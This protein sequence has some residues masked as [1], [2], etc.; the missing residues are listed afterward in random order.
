MIS[1]I[2]DVPP[3]RVVFASAAL[4][5]VGEEAERLKFARTLVIATPGSGA[6]LG[7]EVLGLL[8]ARAMGLHA[9]AVVH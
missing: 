5:R 7:K 8:G 2:H 4:N 9:R 3:Q 6:R 1:F